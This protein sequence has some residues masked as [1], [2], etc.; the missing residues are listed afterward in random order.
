[1]AA[2]GAKD[3]SYFLFALREAELARTVFP[4]GDLTKGAVRAEAAALGLPVAAKPESMEVCFVPDGDAAAFVASHAPPER[5]RPCA[6]CP[7]PRR[8]RSRSDAPRRR[9]RG[10]GAGRP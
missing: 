1:M 8:G 5:H 10:R 7:S 9:R 4:V 2:D 3:Q 6:R